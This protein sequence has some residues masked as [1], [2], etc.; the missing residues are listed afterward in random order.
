ML[1]V[2]WDLSWGCQLQHVHMISPGG[3]VA[4]G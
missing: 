1:A 3:V 2:H 4:L